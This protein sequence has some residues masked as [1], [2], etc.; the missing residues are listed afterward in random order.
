MN[1]CM[2]DCESLSTTPDAVIL[3][4]GAVRFDLETGEIDENN[5]FYASISI[6]SNL[7]IGRRISQDTLNWWLKQDPQAQ[8]VFHEKKMS[9]GDALVDFETWLGGKDL[10][11]W[12]NG[13]DF[14]LPLVA[15][16]YEAL[17]MR[18]PWK[19]WDQRC[20]R[21]FKNLP[22]ADKAPKVVANAAHH[23]LIDAVDQARMA[24]EINAVVFPHTVRQS[25][26]KPALKAVAKPAPKGKK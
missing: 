26:A 25:K 14:D 18:A 15:S 19:F 20:F 10:K 9:L 3:S 11:M 22:G 6:Q 13:A 17:G 23:A 21:T 2:I 24:I 5:G 8:A 7:D 4:L 12:S 1:N 16:A